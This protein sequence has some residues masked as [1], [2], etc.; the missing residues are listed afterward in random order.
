ME[1][2]GLGGGAGQVAELMTSA[3]TNALDKWS[4]AWDGGPFLQLRRAPG[5]PGCP[6]REKVKS[7][8]GIAGGGGVG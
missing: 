3:K 4:W 7:P 6:E 5:C 2:R 8:R 1:T